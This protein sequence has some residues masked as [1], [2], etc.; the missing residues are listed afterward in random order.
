MLQKERPEK[1]NN[2]REYFETK[3]NVV[4]F[5]SL[6]LEIAKR[7]PDLWKQ[8]YDENNRDTNNTN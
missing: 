3:Q 2:E 4:G 1:E 6:L 5:F 7:N 8:I